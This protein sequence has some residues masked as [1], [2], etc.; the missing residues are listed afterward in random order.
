M[1][2]EL[3]DPAVLEH[4]HPVGVVCGVESVRDGDD[5]T[6]GENRGECP[7]G[8]PG[9]RRVERG[10][11]LVEDQRVR[12]GEYE[13][14]QRELLGVG[15]AE[16]TGTVAELRVEAVGQVGVPVGADGDQRGQHLFVGRRPARR[17][18]G[19]RAASR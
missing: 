2:A 15:G 6:P 1:A 9:G 11:G 17:R 16:L 4:R 10:G 13:P 18:R 5:G 8:A 19:C 7:F 3:G 12:V 14:G